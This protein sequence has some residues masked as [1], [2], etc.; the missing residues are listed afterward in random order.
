[1]SSTKGCSLWR[2]AVDGGYR[3]VP[4]LRKKLDPD[5]LGQLKAHR[6]PPEPRRST[7][8]FSVSPVKQIPRTQ[9]F[10]KKGEIFPG[11]WTTSLGFLA[12]QR[13]RPGKRCAPPTKTT[14]EDCRFQQYHHP[15]GLSRS[16][17]KYID[18]MPFLLEID[19]IFISDFLY[20]LKVV[21]KDLRV[22][23]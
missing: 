21:L 20:S 3:S 12:L 11:L 17:F 14:V 1:M 6:S 13:F 4:E 7:S 22:L 15:R 16:R 5:F 8:T 10:I 23:L 2:P 19:F 18:P 9:S